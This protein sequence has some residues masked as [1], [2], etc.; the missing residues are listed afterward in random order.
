MPK[1]SNMNHNREGREIVRLII[2]LAHSVG[3]ETVAE[4]TETAGQIAQLKQLG[5]EMAQGY[6]YS[7]PVN[8]HSASDLLG[9]SEKV[10][11]S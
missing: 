4:G 11:L 9:R 3:L 6:F 2:M 7:P 10:L 5:C 1:S 8:S